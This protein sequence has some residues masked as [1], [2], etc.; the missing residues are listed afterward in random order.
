ME[1]GVRLE[2]REECCRVKMGERRAAEGPLRDKYVAQWH[3]GT[4]APWH[5]GTVLSNLTSG[6]VDDDV[7]LIPQQFVLS[8]EGGDHHSA[9]DGVVEGHLQVIR[10]TWTRVRAMNSKQA[11]TAEGGMSWGRG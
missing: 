7:V 5:R 4:V 9:T 8:D 6:A 2:K 10:L 3:S 1:D 11:C